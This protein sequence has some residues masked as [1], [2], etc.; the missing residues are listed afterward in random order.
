MRR[1]SLPRSG[2]GSRDR[3]GRLLGD[4]GLGLHLGD[5][6]S[7]GFRGEGAV[8]RGLVPAHAADRKIGAAHQ[9]RVAGET[10]EGAPAR[11]RQLEVGA[12]DV[13]GT[14]TDAVLLRGREIEATPRGTWEVV[15]RGA[16]VAI[17]EAL[18]AALLASDKPLGD[19]A[20]LQA[21]R[22]RQRLDQDLTV[23]FSDQVTRLFGSTQPLVSLGRNIGL[24]GLDLLPPAKRDH[25]H[26]LVIVPRKLGEQQIVIEAQHLSRRFGDFVAVDDVSFSIDEGETFGLVGESGSGKTT[27]ARVLLGL[28]A[29]DPGS[30]VT[31]AGK[32]LSP[33]ARRRPREVLR[34]LQ[35][36]F[37]NP[38]SALNRRHSV[39]SLISRPLTRLAGLSGKALQDRLAEP[40]AVVAS[41]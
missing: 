17:L 39:R 9:I 16:D 19:F 31:L 37:Q 4:V 40:R 22:E 28:T 6:E 41:A 15:R 20:T 2:S 34:A 11:Q 33:D 10:G 14:N 8:G 1:A 30:A 32:P 38:D 24:L 21:Y 12:V 3:F 27:L 18:A 36:V 26:E 35:I 25:H 23:G 5:V 7:V 13:G 29:P